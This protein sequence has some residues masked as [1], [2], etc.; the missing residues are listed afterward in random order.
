MD[1]PRH[2]M[3]LGPHRYLILSGLLGGG[4]D[5]DHIPA[6]LGPYFPYG[7][8]PRITAT[9][10]GRPLHI[11]AAVVLGAVCLF[12]LASVLGWILYSWI[13]KPLDHPSPVGGD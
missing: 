8:L 11:P 10:G 3:S 9:L 4:I 7:P 1:H 12:G 2:P 6:L 5:A 13:T